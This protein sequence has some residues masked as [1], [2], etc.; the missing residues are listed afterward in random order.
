MD[1]Q[2]NNIWCQ[3][4]AALLTTPLPTLKLYLPPSDFYPLPIEGKGEGETA[5]QLTQMDPDGAPS[6]KNHHNIWPLIWDLVRF[7]FQLKVI[8]N[9][10]YC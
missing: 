3:H 10:F 5:Q 6:K 1:P 2:K 4:L 7:Y 8:C 9:N